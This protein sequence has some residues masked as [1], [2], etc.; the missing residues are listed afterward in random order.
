MNSLISYNFAANTEYIVRISL[1]S[2]AKCGKVKLAIM[3]TYHHDSYE[4]AYG[5]YGLTTV[6]WGLSNDRVALFRYK[7]SSAGDVTFTMSSSTNTDTYMYIIDPTST[8]AMTRYSGSN[9]T[10]AN[11][12]D[13]DSG[14]GLQ[15]QLKKTV[16]AN[17]EYLVIIAFY[18]PHTMTGKFAINTK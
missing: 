7:F 4:A 8:D 11:L 18:N 14:E 10:T 1:Y 16:V 17:K 13:D 9:Y 3:P 12:Y 2:K 15:A 5:P 6:S